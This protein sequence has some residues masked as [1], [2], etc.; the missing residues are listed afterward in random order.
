MIFFDKSYFLLCGCC[1]SFFVFYASNAADGTKID[2]NRASRDGYFSQHDLCESEIV[3]A[4]KKHGI[5]SRLF[6]AI[7]T[8]ESGRALE[9][10]KKKR[11]WPWT[12]C[13]N[14]KSYYLSTK[15]AAIATVKRL[16]AR[17]I[18]NIDVGCMQ[19]NLLHH[20][21]VFKNLEEAFTP[22]TNVSYA[23]KYFMD[24]K[25]TFNS[26]TRAVGFYHSRHPKYYKPYCSL[27]L[28]AWKDVRNRH[29]NMSPMVRQASSNIK[30]NISF[31]PSFYSMIDTTI[32]AKLHKLGRQ[33]I[34]K[35]VPKFFT[36]QEK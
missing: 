31:L 18:R 34:T 22:K 10:S 6:M 8:V 3:T 16:F 1:A 4:E 24:L 9:T 12:I 26:W 19:V 28:N 7:G 14:G 32:S 11:P 15:S 35:S 36:N 5:P 13:A 25:K 30:S 29:V 23:A 17:G 27:V 21:N 33:S 20:R 2:A